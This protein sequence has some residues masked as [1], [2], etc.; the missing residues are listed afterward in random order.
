MKK[1]LYSLK[2][3][4]LGNEVLVDVCI[5]LGDLMDKGFKNVSLIK[6]ETGHMIGYFSYMPVYIIGP[7]F[8]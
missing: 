4:L 7:I 6:E 5:L 3:Y 2:R 1:Y 8:E